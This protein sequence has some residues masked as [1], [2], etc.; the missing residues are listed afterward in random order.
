MLPLGIQPQ[1]GLLSE[2]F[3][4]CS[5]CKFSL[6]CRG[7]QLPS[8][9]QHDKNGNSHLVQLVLAITQGKGCFYELSLDG[10]T[11]AHT[12]YP[13]FC[14]MYVDVAQAAS[15]PIDDQLQAQ[16]LFIIQSAA[17]WRV[18]EFATGPVLV[19]MILESF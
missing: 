17:M 13:S 10:I 19:D 1:A 16:E 12:Q 18:E 6:D 14:V 15:D 4:F 5:P 7:L 3:L 2:P 8:N 11:H 9:S